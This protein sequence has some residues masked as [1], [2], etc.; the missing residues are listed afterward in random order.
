MIWL[1]PTSCWRWG[2]DGLLKCWYPTATLH[3]S[4][5]Q[6]IFIAVE[7]LLSCIEYLLSTHFPMLYTHSK[8][9]RHCWRSF[10]KSPFSDIITSLWISSASSK[11][12]TPKE[13][14]SFL[15]HEKWH[16]AKSG[17]LQWVFQHWYLFFLMK[18][19]FIKSA[20][21]EYK[22]HLSR[23]SLAL[24]YECIPINI[25]K[26]EGR[27]HSRLL[28][29]ITFIMISLCLHVNHCFTHCY[30]SINFL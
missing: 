10:S 19:S 2:Q 20:L 3:G 8:H 5:A 17:R 12:D 30:L 22:I 13:I 14:F 18:N 4:T 25:S 26:L 23:Q 27:I 28:L 11:W 16:G 24:V 9:W 6:C 21:C 7:T 15:D 1:P 29:G